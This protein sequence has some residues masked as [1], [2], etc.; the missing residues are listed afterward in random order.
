[1]TASSVLAALLLFGLLG[2]LGQGIRAIVGLN[3]AG[4]FKS[5]TPSEQSV[6]SAAYLLFSLMLGFIAGMLGGIALKYQNLTQ[7]TADNW[8]DLLG[9]VASGYD[10]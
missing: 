7:I 6:F 8:K 2:L 4:A 5:N 9:I 10:I 3:N 1:M